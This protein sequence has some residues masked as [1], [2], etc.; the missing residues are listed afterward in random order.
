MQL[1]SVSGNLFF[2]VAFIQCIVYYI[3]NFSFTMQILSRNKIFAVLKNIFSSYFKSILIYSMT[4]RLIV[5][6]LGMYSIYGDILAIL[7]LLAYTF[8][9]CVSVLSNVAKCVYSENSQKNNNTS[10]NLFVSS[11]HFVLFLFFSVSVILFVLNRFQDSA[12][13]KNILFTF[14]S[15]LCFVKFV[16]NFATKLGDVIADYKNKVLNNIEE[17]QNNTVFDYLDNIGDIIGDML[18]NFVDLFMLIILIMCCININI[19]YDDYIHK[20]F[21]LIGKIATF[22]LTVAIFQTFVSYKRLFGFIDYVF[23]FNSFVWLLIDSLRRNITIWSIKSFSLKSMHPDIAYLMFFVVIVLLLD[24]TK[25]FNI[26]ESTYKTNK[27]YYE[28]IGSYCLLHSFGISLFLTICFLFISYLLGKVVGSIYGTFDFSEIMLGPIL[29]QYLFLFSCYYFWKSCIGVIADSVGGFLEKIRMQRNEQNL[30]STI[31]PETIAI[32]E[33]HDQIGNVSKFETRVFLCTV[34]FVTVVSNL[35]TYGFL[36]AVYFIIF[37]IT[38]LFINLWKNFANKENITY[39]EI[40]SKISIFCALFINTF[41]LVMSRL[42]TQSK[43]YPVWHENIISIIYCTLCFSLFSGI[44]GGLLDI[45]KKYSKADRT[46]DELQ[47]SFIQHDILGDFLKD[48]LSPVLYTI[49][50]LSLYIFVCFQ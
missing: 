4:V 14:F 29:W 12:V 32:L 10:Y 37:M 7:F 42:V 19:N 50:V 15:I 8:V 38:S 40:F 16:G 9:A 26:Y 11:I 28:T 1:Q 43:I 36:L 17:D 41:Y 23:I 34:F 39:S 44:Y 48:V 49:S 35:K 47:K 46:S 31:L 45:Y 33:E 6:I 21:T 22:F 2:L 3:V 5:L 20:S 27:S 30:P 18:S 13:K 24:F 25:R